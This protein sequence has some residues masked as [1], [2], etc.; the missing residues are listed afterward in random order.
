M[1]KKIQGVKWF[2]SWE[3]GFHF[4]ATGEDLSVLL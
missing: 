4:T 2:V 3:G 1:W